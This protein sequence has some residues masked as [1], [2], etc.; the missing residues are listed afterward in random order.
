MPLV[1]PRIDDRS[2][3]QILAEALAR[4]P[5]HNPEWTNFNDSDPGVTLIQL[6]AYM[7]ESMLYRSNLIPARNRRKFLQLLGIPM[8][9]AASAQGIVTLI[10]PK[11]PPKALTLSAGEE[12]FA[13]AVPF[14]SREGLDVLPIEARIYYKRPLDASQ[15]TDVAPLYAELYSDLAAEGS[16]LVYYETR[17]LVAP[18]AGYTFPEVDLATGAVGEALW[19]ALLAS[20]ADAVTDTRQAIANKELSLGILPAMSNASR[21][22]A[23]GGGLTAD[24]PQLIYELPNV[25]ADGLLPTDGSPRN[26]SYRQLTDARATGDLTVEPGVVQLSLPSADALIL[27]SNLEPREEGS[28]DFPPLLEDREVAARVVTWVRVRLRRPEEGTVDASRLSVRL[29]WMGINAARV[30]Q[31][32]RVNLELPGLGNGEPGQRFTLVN[33]PVLPD[34]LQVLVNGQTWTR[35]DDL[36]SA[37]PEVPVR[38]PQLPPGSAEA[39][40]R[41][42]DARVFVLDR[43]AGELRFGDG[44]RGARPPFGAVIQVR[45]E[46]GGGRQ[47]NVGIGAI[48]RAS[49]AGGIK[50]FNP[51]PTWGGDDAESIE[52]AE[53]R[54]P[55]TLQHRDRAVS[56]AD[57]ATIAKET[58][59]VRIGRI[60]V[61]PLFHPELGEGQ[62]D[63]VVT[64]MP[65]PAEDPASP[66]APRPDRLFLDAICRYIE[67][68]R[69][70]TTEVH[71][72]GPI[73]KAIWVSVG[74]EVMPGRDVSTV[75]EAIRAALSQFLSPLTGGFE[76]LGWPLRKTV[77]ALELWAVATRVEG[78]AKVVR[79]LLSGDSGGAVDRIYMS[80]LELPGG[81]VVAAQP[82]EP[83]AI[84]EL[85]GDQNTQGL[86]GTNRVPVPIIPLEC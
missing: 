65:I 69:L 7:T 72:L 70:I 40:T 51:L 81:V 46:Y 84:A 30:T 3:Q 60:E 8:R 85:R 18:T 55:L 86:S 52:A 49:L 29:S 80:G 67:P 12:V 50:V 76:G 58:P 22:L 62:A 34:T 61:L 26:A 54:I 31:R 63:G 10:A 79:V 43:E 66:D 78:V 82:G 73:Y 41:P 27:W 56:A 44:L 9:P 48:S 28:G 14:R 57:F 68:R 2:Y 23:P 77:E 47:G 71:I 16:E 13:G 5:V 36:N 17:E 21:M 53:Q 6:Y 42:E 59:G 39:L 19:V 74:F 1:N 20:R 32:A 15:V 83:Q 11:G 45:Y 64:L 37:L 75:R 33:R 38:S 25:P 4:I 24:A 35:I